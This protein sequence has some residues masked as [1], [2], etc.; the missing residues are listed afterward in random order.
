MAQNKNIF[1]QAPLYGLKDASDAPSISTEVS[2][3]KS[4]VIKTVDALF[5]VQ[6]GFI[7]IGLTGLASLV[8]GITAL[9]IV[10]INM[11][12][13]VQWSPVEFI[14]QLFWLRLEPPSTTY[15]LGIPPMAEGGWW[16]LAVF[17]LTLALLFGCTRLF[18]HAWKNGSGFHVPITFVAVVWLYLVLGFIRPVLLGTWSEAAPFGIFPQLEWIVAF[19]IRYGNLAYNPFI[20]LSI[21]FLCLS[22]SLFVVN[23]IVDVSRRRKGAAQGTIYRGA[24]WFA[25]FCPVLAG[26]GL[27][28]TGTV[29][30]NWFVW[31]V[32]HGLGLTNL[33]NS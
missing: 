11:L 24:W 26:I 2:S 6:V 22:V 3:E 25:V 23:S 31:S 16:L 18:M 7:S 33:F 12:A 8:C 4:S 1:T 27:L 19:S 9:A 5:H 15:Q 28:V 20:I 30:D 14:N 21:V 10:T 32:E 29:V 17:F 13:S